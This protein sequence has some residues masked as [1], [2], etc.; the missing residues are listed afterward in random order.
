MVEK[1]EVWL[2]F[3][4]KA[5]QKVVSLSLV[6]DKI[7]FKYD[8]SFLKNGWNISPFQLKF[9]ERIQMC[10]KAP[11]DDLFGVFGDSLPDA[12][13]RLIVDR[14]LVSN[15]KSPGKYTPLDRLSLVG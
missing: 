12:W 2:R 10:P 6:K 14:Y 1:L 4:A 5:T 13:G 11:F 7:Y 3:S 9:D 15:H 8:A